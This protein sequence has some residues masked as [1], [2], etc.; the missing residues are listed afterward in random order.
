MNSWA[1]SLT[2]TRMRRVAVVAPRDVLRDALVC[3]ADAGCVELDTAVEPGH[4]TPGPAARRLQ[5]LGS[6]PVRPLLSPT[7]PDLDA[8]QAAGRADLL[9]GEAQLEG[10]REAAV[11]H[12]AVAAL[13]GWCPAGE[14]P[15]LAARLA[16]LGGALVPLRAPRGIDP[17]TRLY[18]TG[19]V[20]PAELVGDSSLGPADRRYLD[21]DEAFAH[22]LVHQGRDELRTLDQTMDRAWQVLLSLPR[23]QLAMLPADFLDAHGAT[24]GG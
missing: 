19:T 12:H 15:R 23:S 17:P 21:F 14:V 1:D 20:R 16:E 13:A 10:Y 22:G 3:A 24:E 11:R 4:G 9:M 18:D 7:A 8:L 6:G 2:P 5:T